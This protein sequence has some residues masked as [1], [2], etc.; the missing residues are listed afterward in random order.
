[1]DTRVWCDSL[2]TSTFSF[3]QKY[4]E[5]LQKL[6]QILT[7]LRE[8]RENAQKE[9]EELRVQYRLS[10]DRGDALNSQFTETCRKLKESEYDYLDV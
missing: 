3:R 6:E 4:E 5:D 2:L 1:M 7:S 10:E 8:E 9:N